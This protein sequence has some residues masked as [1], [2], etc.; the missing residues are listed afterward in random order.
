MSK[1]L[2]E[3]ILPLPFTLAAIATDSEAAVVYHVTRGS[4]RERMQQK[5]CTGLAAL[6]VLAPIASALLGL[7]GVLPIEGGHGLGKW[8]F[9]SACFVVVLLGTALSGVLAWRRPTQRRAPLTLVW[10][11][12]IAL[13]AFTLVFGLPFLT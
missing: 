8:L 6:L 4:Y 13:L 10:I 1:P 7:G 2:A 9:L 11:G 5:L 12:A 3:S